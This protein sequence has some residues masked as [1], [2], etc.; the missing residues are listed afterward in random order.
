M[1]S[2]NGEH[3][4]FKCIINNDYTRDY[5]INQ[6]IVLDRRAGESYEHVIMK[7]FSYF[8]FY[9][10]DLKIEA[11][12]HQHYKPDLVRTDERGIPH[13]WVDCGQ[14]SIVKLDSISNKNRNTFIDIVKLNKKAIESYWNNAQ[15]KIRHPERIRLFATDEGFVEEFISKM[16]TRNT[17]SVT[18]SGQLDHMYIELNGK[19]LST[20]IHKINVKL[21][22][23]IWD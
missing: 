21:K 17:V 3:L 2:K 6:R 16:S 18:I 5:G 12:V 8:W 14:T 10:K 13:Q 20:D 4:D 15:G 19:L 11:D 9:H 7:L 23:D 1:T 22:D